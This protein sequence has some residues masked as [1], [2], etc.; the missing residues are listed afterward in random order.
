MVVDYASK[1][2]FLRGFQKHPTSWDQ[3]ELSAARKT[4]LCKYIIAAKYFI[5]N[6][7]CII[8]QIIKAYREIK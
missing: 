8:L 7:I 6:K 4:H 5:F 3:K 1:N 2:F